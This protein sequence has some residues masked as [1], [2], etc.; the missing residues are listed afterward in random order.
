MV[1]TPD[2]SK[3]N[4]NNDLF[5]RQLVFIANSEDTELVKN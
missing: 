2:E 4:R 5:E 3:V 1:L